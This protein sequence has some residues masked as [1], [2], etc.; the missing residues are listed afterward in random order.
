[1]VKNGCGQSSD[2]TLKLTVSEEWTDER[3]DF[4]HVNTYSQKLKADQIF[5]GGMIKNGC[6]QCDHGTLKLIVSHKWT[7]G[8]NWFFACLCKLRKLKV[9]SMIQTSKKHD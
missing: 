3:T 5:L 2:K 8:V 9:D 6:G 1:M 4:L 7:D